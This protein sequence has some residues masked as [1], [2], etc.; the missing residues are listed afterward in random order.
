MTNAPT[1]HTTTATHTEAGHGGPVIKNETT[2]HP[3][4]RFLLRLLRVLGLCCTV[5]LVAMLILLVLLPRLMGW[6]P[7]T[8]L[9]GSMEPAIPVGSQVVVD[10]I[11][12]EEELANITTGDVITF[13]PEPDDPT[14][15]THRVI[16]QGIR[17]EGGIAL[18]TRGDANDADDPG[19]VT[20]QQIRGVTRYHVPYVGYVASL[21]DAQQKKTGT[22][23]V[24]VILFG[25]AGWNIVAAL[26]DR[27]HDKPT[28]DASSGDEPKEPSAIN[29]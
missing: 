27:R 14:L 23:I 16:S 21:L 15:V 20:L 25:Y 7:L 29:R 10:R 4:R 26:R 1:G 12:T 17:G 2:D 5:I 9:S 18:K 11:E 8:V 3:S 19:T 22:I 6:V 24:A 28:P 13:M